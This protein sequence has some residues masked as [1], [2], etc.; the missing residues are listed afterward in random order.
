MC[1]M[2]IDE[3]PLTV[4][5]TMAR[6]VALGQCK[7]CRLVGLALCQQGGGC[8][9]QAAC[10]G[11]SLVTLLGA[12]T[13]TTLAAPPCSGRQRRLELGTPWRC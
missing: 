9:T 5:W 8:V 13:Q 2:M 10:S 4:A 12:P 7:Q 11:C 1:L 3:G 6:T